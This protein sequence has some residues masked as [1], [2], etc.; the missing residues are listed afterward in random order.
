MNVKKSKIFALTLLTALLMLATLSAIANAQTTGTVIVLDTVGGTTDP[1][2]GTT[3]PAAGTSVTFTATADT[4]F[5]F[6]SWI[7]STD[8]GTNIATTNPVTLPITGGVNYT[9]QANFVPIQA[10]PGANFP[11]N[12]ATA[13]TVV[14]LAGAGGTTTPAAG[15]YA[16]DTATSLN[17][18]ATPSSGWT[19]SHWV[20]SGPNLSHGGYPFTATPTNNPYNVNHGYGATYSY[21]PVFTPTGVTEPT[22]VGGAT[23]SPTPGP[24]SGLTSDQGIEIGLV[25]VIIVIL[26]AFGVFAMRKKK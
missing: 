11:S 4:G 23:A 2:P 16:M 7:V 1:V 18:T 3:T 22:P 6:D 24:S 13:A 26:I 20:I 8:L 25:V 5:V 9:V 12:L 19:F 10:I 17:L 21:Q 15:T 14:V